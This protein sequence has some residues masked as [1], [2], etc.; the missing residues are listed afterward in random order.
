MAAGLVHRPGRRLRRRHGLSP[1]PHRG[2]RR[3]LKEGNAALSSANK[4][5]F[6]LNCELENEIS[7]RERAEIERAALDTRLQHLRYLY[8][9]RSVLSQTRTPN[10]A[11]QDAG[12][13][14]VEVLSAAGVGGVIVQH[15]GSVLHFGD[16]EEICR[17]RYERPIAWGGKTRGRFQL[18]CDVAL[19]EAQERALVNETAGQIARAWK[20]DT[21]RASGPPE[22]A[23]SSLP[24]VR[25]MY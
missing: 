12:E 16:P 10:Q 7:E 23:E 20:P 9:L 25:L 1:V 6:A 18:H 5:L 15:N 3:K 17:T 8:R 13:L 2:A 21:P 4:E 11:V 24:G 14:A 22:E 19:T